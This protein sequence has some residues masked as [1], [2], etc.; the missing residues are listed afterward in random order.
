MDP[1][2]GVTMGCLIL[3][4]GREYELY[5][6]EEPPRDDDVGGLKCCQSRLLDAFPDVDDDEPNPPRAELLSAALLPAPKPCPERFVDPDGGE[7]FCH[8]GLL[9]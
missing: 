8:P 5:E 9:D 4:G 7:N 6:L 3:R 1:P 2:R